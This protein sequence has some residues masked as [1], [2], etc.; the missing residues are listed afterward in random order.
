MNK[1]QSDIYMR[2]LVEIECETCDIYKLLTILDAYREANPNCDE[3]DYMRPVLDMLLEK[4][5]GVKKAII[6]LGEDFLDY[7]QSTDANV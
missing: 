5:L 6:K 4:S 3:L 2:S 7:N 1:E